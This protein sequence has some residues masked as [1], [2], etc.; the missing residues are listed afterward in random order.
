[1]LIIKP[2]VVRMPRNINLK[3]PSSINS[4]GMY[5]ITN[6]IAA[7]PHTGKTTPDKYCFT[8][9]LQTFLAYDIITIFPPKAKILIIG[10]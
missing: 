4:D 10:M 9:N 1:M 3:N 2:V 8:D 7:T 5:P 6:I